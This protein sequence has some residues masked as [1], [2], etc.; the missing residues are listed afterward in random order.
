[1]VLDSTCYTLQFTVAVQQSL[2][3][4]LSFCAGFYYSELSIELLDLSITVSGIGVHF[5]YLFKCSYCISDSK[6]EVLRETKVQ[7]LD[8]LLFQAQRKREAATA[9]GTSVHEQ[10]KKC[11]CDDRFQY[12]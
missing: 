4:Q 1:M 2:L 11:K 3:S 9:S 8:Q 10:H 5:F 7:R 6:E 12:L